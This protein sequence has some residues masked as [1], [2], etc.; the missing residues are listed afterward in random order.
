MDC[1]IIAMSIAVLL[2]S[3]ALLPSDVRWSYKDLQS[4]I[5][6]G[7]LR[8]RTSSAS[9]TMKGP[10]RHSAIISSIH[11]QTPDAVE[12]AFAS[13]DMVEA[14]TRGKRYD[15]QAKQEPAR[16]TLCAFCLT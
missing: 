11:S 16:P 9:S 15:F 2:S 7:G 5:P 14:T 6:I 10:S 12:K 13:P 1:L 8:T 4:V 3:K